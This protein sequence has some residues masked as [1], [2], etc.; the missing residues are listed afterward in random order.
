MHAELT[1]RIKRIR[2]EFQ[3]ELD[4]VVAW[5]SSN[6]LDTKGGG[7]YGEIDNQCRPNPSA[8]KGLVLNTRI[9]W[10]F[11]RAAL[12]P[13]LSEGLQ[14]AA[15]SLADRAFTYFMEHFHDAQFGGAYWSL[16]WQG[17]V[18]EPKK[19]TYGIAFA[20]YGLTAYYK[21]TSKPEVLQIAMSYF[22][23]IEQHCLDRKNGGYHE[24]R[25]QDWGTAISAPMSEKDLD[26]PKTMDNHLHIL[27]AY[28][29]LYDSHPAPEVKA[30]LRQCLMIFDRRVLDKDT[31]HLKLF[32]SEDWQQDNSH[33]FSY[34]HD[35]EYS[36]LGLEALRALNSPGLNQQV[37]PRLQ[38]IASICQSEGL[39]PLGQ[40]LDSY[41]IQNQC[42]GGCNEWWV[43][44]E[45][46]V[47][48]FNAYQVSGNTLYL[49]SFEKVWDFIKKYH[50][51]ADYG[52]WFS[53]ST[54]DQM[55]GHNSCK[56][57]FWK[58]PYHNGRALLEI[59]R[60]CD[61]VLADIDRTAKTEKTSERRNTYD[62]TF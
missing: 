15:R 36:W 26:S 13:Y 62:A 61:Y 55:N 9:L 49:A 47:G 52:E 31:T 3:A 53:C 56:V 5:W 50:I 40:L 1:D 11:S 37:A 43:Q 19:Q 2:Q 35:I 21:L 32:M 54:I 59:I 24:C 18:K 45:A 20:I 34:G 25:T 33:S 6:A 17:Q 10:F 51:D 46:T 12:S 60:R 58:G 16:D 7:F 8:D 57:S 42:F 38:S 39:S 4:A 28:T 41:D 14:A 30:S 23:C 29:S 22:S 48:F 27:E 44:A